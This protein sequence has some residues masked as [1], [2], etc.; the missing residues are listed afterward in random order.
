MYGQDFYICVAQNQR[1]KSPNEKTNAIFFTSKASFQVCVRLC[2]WYNWPLIHFRVSKKLYLLWCVWV[3]VAVK[4]EEQITDFLFLA[5]NV[6]IDT[7][8]QICEKKNYLLWIF[9]CVHFRWAANR[10][11]MNNVLNSRCDVNAQ[12]D[13][14]I[15][16]KIRIRIRR[17]IDA[18]RWANIQI[19]AHMRDNWTK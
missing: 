4:N 16:L 15:Y 19:L 18:S 9:A 12:I 7:K 2:A 11:P 6:K 13:A 17:S 14:S 8:K 5:T 10:E 3:W 1:K